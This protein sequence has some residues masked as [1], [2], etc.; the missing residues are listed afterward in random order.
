M[1]RVTLPVIDAT[2]KAE[3][4]RPPRERVGGPQGKGLAA[5]SNSRARLLLLVEDERKYYPSPVMGRLYWSV[6]NAA[7]DALLIFV[8]SLL[9]TTANKRVGPPPLRPDGYKPQKGFR[10]FRG[11][12]STKDETPIYGIHQA[13]SGFVR[14]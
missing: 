9:P 1:F 6:D 7:S 8:W 2:K 13:V 14:Q 4:R 5:P 11:R 10:S 12:A 3:A